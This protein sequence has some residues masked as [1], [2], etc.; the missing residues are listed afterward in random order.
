MNSS[1]SFFLFTSFMLLRYFIVVGSEECL[2][3]YLGPLLSLRAWAS[4][5]KL[6]PSYTCT[7]LSPHKTMRTIMGRTM[8]LRDHRLYRVET[9]PLTL[10]I[11][12]TREL[13]YGTVS[14]FGLALAH[15]FSQ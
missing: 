4:T 8:R 1:L 15:S 2:A 9:S 6:S 14:V 7:I 5:P 3:T 11:H 10:S 13:W 12:R